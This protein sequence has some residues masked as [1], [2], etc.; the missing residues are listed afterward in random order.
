MA[1]HITPA[2]RF[3][4]LFF[5]SVFLSSKGF[6]GPVASLLIPD[7]LFKGDVPTITC[8][9]PSG[10]TETGQSFQSTTLNW[11]FEFGSLYTIQL[12]S[13][14]EGGWTDVQTNYFGSSYTLYPLTFGQTYSWRLKRTCTDGSSSDWSPV[15]TFTLSCF[16]PSVTLEFINNGSTFIRSAAQDDLAV[17]YTYRWRLAGTEAW[18]YRSNVNTR[19]YNETPLVK[20]GLYEWQVRSECPDG[21]SS[22]YCE[23]KTSPVQCP[24]VSGLQE[25][26]VTP[27]SA[28]VSWIAYYD[29]Y[30][31]LWRKKGNTKW[32]SRKE[33][34]FHSGRFIANQI[35]GLEAG[36]EYE[37][38]V[39]L[40]CPDGAISTSKIRTFVTQCTTQL[41][42]NLNNA[43]VYAT[44]ALVNWT[45]AGKYTSTI[46]AKTYFQIRY[47]SASDSTWHE[48]EKLA[49]GNAYY[50][51]TGLVSNQQYE[52]QV[53]Q[54]CSP[55]IYTDYSSGKYFIT[56][57]SEVSDMRTFFIKATSAYLQWFL[58]GSENTVIQW[59]E[60]GSD[61]W[62]SASADNSYELKGLNANTEYEWRIRYHCDRE[63]YSSSI[64]FKTQKEVICPK[65][66]SASSSII[67]STSVRLS[68]SL[69]NSADI[70]TYQVRWR[71]VGTSE[72]SYSPP[73]TQMSYTVTGLNFNL[74]YEWDLVYICEGVT[75]VYSP[76]Y[77]RI[78]PQINCPYS[79]IYEYSIGSKAITLQITGSWLSKNVDNELQVRVSGAV[80]WSS[81]KGITIGGF[82]SVTGLMP[83]TVYQFRCR[84]YC[85]D[86]FSVIRSFTTLT[87]CDINE[88]NETITEAIPLSGTSVETS[89]LCLDQSL[90]KDWFKWEYK[91]ISY[92]ILVTP[93]TRYGTGPYKLNL[94]ISNEIL[95]VKTA[96]ATDTYADS[97]DTFLQ[98]Y[99]ADGKT[100]L[101]ENDDFDQYYSEVTLYLA[102]PFSTVRPGRWSDPVIWSTFR[103]PAAIDP[104]LIRHP[105]K[106][107]AATTGKASRISYDAG[108]SL[109]LESGAKLK[110]TP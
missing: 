93:I 77:D 107:P 30:F 7:S 17:T 37:W 96:P 68:W 13:G 81:I 12:K 57:C 40:R 103:V 49:D 89:V 85:S 75:S 20:N 25:V 76:Q 58:S 84:A 82:N 38:C 19:D 4:F 86:Q 80:S 43:Q 27:T 1:I 104:V 35:G 16:V 60:T 62:Q 109:Q 98:I 83:N 88:P 73:T 87:P 53:R 2:Y 8:T 39:Q 69:S 45:N 28:V 55:S 34:T 29:I 108:G 102:K 100:L 14:P 52:W 105:V 15:R 54:Y 31:L 70:T 56:R 90:D 51:I 72:W 42:D 67:D 71:Q 46:P 101:A 24:Q 3:F 32:Y 47:R 9:P 66:N 26:Y 78:F 64:K 59:R 63:K 110:I 92:Y 94:S 44:S 79:A 61:N 5:F 36:T 95:T 50:L 23:I 22:A 97:T 11:T 91:G 41:N 106:L 10:L 74:K 33:Y 65:V 21:S 99:A 6:T 48:S 18:N